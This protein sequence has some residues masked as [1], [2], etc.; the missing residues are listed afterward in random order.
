MK[1]VY[2]YKHPSFKQESE[3]RL[4]YNSKPYVY[5]EE[6]D[7][8]KTIIRTF[9]NEIETLTPHA[10]LGE[11]SV[12][13][14]KGKLISYRPLCIKNLQMYRNIINEIVIGPKSSVSSRDVSI[15]FNANGFNI[16]N[17]IERSNITYQ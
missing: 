17:K 10:K 8:S 6:S 15:L 11:I 13:S 1:K 16:P 2:F 9:K 14:S 12:Y 3:Y 5:T 4:V 7:N